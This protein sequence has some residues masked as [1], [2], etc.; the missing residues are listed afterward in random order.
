MI[1]DGS[2]FFC[3]PQHQHDLKFP[4]LVLQAERF[5][6]DRRLI[7]NVHLDALLK[8][9]PTLVE[10]CKGTSIQEKDFARF[11]RALASLVGKDP[12]LSCEAVFKIETVL[13]KRFSHLPP[14][15]QPI[16][17]LG[18]N[19]KQ[20]VV[21]RSSLDSDVF[22]SMLK[23]NFSES[24]ASEIDWKNMPEG[25]FDAICQFLKTG[26]CH[27]ET[28]CLPH[29]L[30]YAHLYGLG[31]LF[32]YSLNHYFNLTADQNLQKDNMISSVIKESH[33]FL[34]QVL[35]IERSD[36]NDKV[37]K[38]GDEFTPLFKSLSLS[39]T[40]KVPL[41]IALANNSALQGC[42]NHLFREKSPH[43]MQFLDHLCRFATT[44]AQGDAIGRNF[45]QAIGIYQFASKFKNSRAQYGL[46]E[47]MKRALM[48]D[49]NREESRKWLQKATDLG[50]APA[51][52]CKGSFC[53]DD[54]WSENRFE[55]ACLWYSK[56]AAQNFMPAQT[57]L[58]YMYSH[59]FGVKRNEKEAVRW[60]KVAADNGDDKAQYEL[61]I[62]YECAFEFDLPG[63]AK[64]AAKYYTM[65][66]ER[67]NDSAQMRLALLYQEGKGV[68]K[69]PQKAVELFLKASDRNN[70]SRYFLGQCYEKGD[71]VKQ[72]YKEAA[73][74]YQ[75]AAAWYDLARL[76]EKGLGVEK[77]I[78]RAKE[79]FELS[80]GHE[81]FIRLG[82]IYENGIDG[83]IDLAKAR[84]WYLKAVENTR[85]DNDTMEK[86]AKWLKEGIG[87]PKDLAK[88]QFF[89]NLLEDNY[90][91]MCRDDVF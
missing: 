10:K 5:T 29:V 20:A 43:K 33:D 34:C 70:N 45:Y 85:E 30:Y 24:A 2:R 48:A 46:V 15:L 54:L 52:Y 32:N 72:D 35:G 25:C 17:L 63:S 13:Q 76:F 7:R 90:A 88:A 37:M 6:K 53:E 79:L 66:A 57:K 82:E 47:L 4:D 56:A 75:K 62:I 27:I 22:D 40:N 86:L 31:I 61:G 50:F 58:G 89:D 28:A 38:D 87:G 51:L 8:D 83:S 3:S 19:N 73:K 49:P 68:D 1:N 26:T 41:E 12:E 69:N 16:A 44:L 91:G 64:L 14:P 18:P 9:L 36:A 74:W 65:T 55:E 39:T 77:N 60:Y 84:T 71:G 78:V 11:D 23:G 59:E 80:G 21:P 81:A 42:C 67:G